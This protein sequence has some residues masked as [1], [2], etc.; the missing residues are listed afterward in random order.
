MQ[1]MLM[2]ELGGDDIKVMN[3][4]DVDGGLLDF[5]FVY[6]DIMLYLD[7]ILLLELGLG[8]DCDGFCDLD[9]EICICV[10]R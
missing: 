3:E 5:E 4:V 9:F 2:E 10:K 8:C 7:G 6:L 1:F